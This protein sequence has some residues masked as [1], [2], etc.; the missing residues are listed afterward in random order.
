MKPRLFLSIIF[1]T[2]GFI[3]CKK[4]GQTNVNVSSIENRI[5]DR[6]NLLS[7]Q[8][9]E[10][11][12]AEIQKLERTVGSQ[13]AV[14]IID[15]LN[16]EKIEAYSIRNFESLKLGRER[17]KDGIQILLAVKDH[18]IRIEVGY[19]L[20]LII[21]DSTA[22][23]IIKRDM[24]PKFKEKEYYKGLELAIDEIIKLIEQNKQLV[25]KMP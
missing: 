11:L 18:K 25:G 14:V 24:I 4:Q 7:H 16:G 19:G 12:F 10:A 1:L 15:T 5:I 23:H 20:E 17:L 3:A 9:K 6:V 13:I 2:V 8:E 22:S 21:K